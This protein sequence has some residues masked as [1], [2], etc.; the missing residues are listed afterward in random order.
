MSDVPRAEIGVLDSSLM[1][2]IE[3]RLDFESRRSALWTS[4]TL[5]D[6]LSATTRRRQFPGALLSGHRKSRNLAPFAHQFGLVGSSFMI[7]VQQ[8][9][10]GAGRRR[11]RGHDL[12]CGEPLP[13]EPNSRWEYRWPGTTVAHSKLKVCRKSQ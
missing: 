9:A 8:K 13:A 12:S 6:I 4:A 10:A 11:W 2:E 1:P 5:Q 3:C 7:A